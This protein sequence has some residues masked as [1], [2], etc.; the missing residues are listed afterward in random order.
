MNF[1]DLCN[2]VYTLTNRPDLVNETQLAV[3]SATLRAHKIDFFPKDL[4]ENYFSFTSAAYLQQFPTA[5]IPNFRVLK[6]IR[7]YYPNAVPSQSFPQNIPYY[8]AGGNLPDGRFFD[9]IDPTAVLDSYQLNKVDVAYLAGNAI[10]LRSGDQVQY[11]LVGA[12]VS[13]DI[14]TSGWN[15]WI[16]NEAP[17]A[18]VYDAAAVVFKTIGYD[19]Q[20]AAYN[21]LKKMEWTE[22]QTQNILAT[23]S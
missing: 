13:P 23:G 9:I 12:Y 20:N 16:A 5:L 17:Y 14:T 6:Y 3:K 10:Q 15:S 21:D 22:L 19:E 18:I 4:Y 1:T 11:I 2:E 8:S 7:K